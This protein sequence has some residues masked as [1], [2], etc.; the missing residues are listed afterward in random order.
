MFV[1]WQGRPS[2]LYELGFDRHR[3]S[4]N[5]PIV[6]LDLQHLPDPV[7]ALREMKRVCKPGGC[8]TST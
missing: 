3:E 2:A 1:A 4:F 7:R 5:H 8:S 6:G